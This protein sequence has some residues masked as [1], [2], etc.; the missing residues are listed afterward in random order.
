MVVVKEPVACVDLDLAVR[1]VDATAPTTA[2][3]RA[4]RPSIDILR[5]RRR[6]DAARENLRAS[7]ARQSGASCASSEPVVRNLE[8]KAIDNQ[9]DAL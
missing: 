3:E 8:H 2:D 5:R 7:W 9:I 6:R 4:D 1:D